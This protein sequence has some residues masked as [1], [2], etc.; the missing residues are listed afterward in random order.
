MELC[1]KNP[2]FGGPYSDDPKW[3]WA[4]GYANRTAELDYLPSLKICQFY[5]WYFLRKKINKQKEE[6]LILRD[7][8]WQPK[9]WSIVFWFFVSWKRLEFVN[10]STEEFSKNVSE[11]KKIIEEN[12]NK[13]I[14]RRSSVL[15]R[16]RTIHKINHNY[17]KIRAFK[18][19]LLIL[20]SIYYT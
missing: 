16:Y 2:A 19:Y 3:Q 4:F 11:M 13:V 9:K 1:P 20:N 7:R 14:T 17:D 6:I 15:K 10:K 12:K 8:K 18:P 5:V